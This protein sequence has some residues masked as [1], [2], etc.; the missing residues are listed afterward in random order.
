[1]TV[2]ITGATSGIGRDLAVLFSHKGYDLILASRN[3]KR[4]EQIQR[5]LPSNV[6]IITVDLSKKEDCFYLYEQTKSRNIDILVNNAGFGYYG[7][8]W[9]NPIENDIEM[10]NLNVQCVHILTK[11]FLDDFRKRNS[12]YIMNIASFAGFSSGPL[13]CSY[14]ATKNYVLRLSEGLYEE[15]RREGS[16]VHVCAVCPGPVATEFNSRAGVNGFLAKE[17]SSMEVAKISIREMFRKNPVII[18][19]S[20]L[21]MGY[22]G[23]KFLNEKMMMRV[24]YYFQKT[25]KGN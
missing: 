6:E 14:Y 23:E 10:I 2:L 16:K 21:K 9:D 7:N 20:L 19:S 8:F 13:M 1:M 18:T 22:W 12:G 5:R 4:M 3:T 15:L 25:K 24:A 11:L 17:Q